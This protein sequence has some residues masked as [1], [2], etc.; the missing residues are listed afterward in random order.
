LKIKRPTY[1]TVEV[2][3]DIRP[4]FYSTLKINEE[5]ITGEPC[6]SKDDAEN[7]AARKAL[8]I[9]EKMYGNKLNFV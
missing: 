2:K 4:T 3:S 6:N 9:L 8:P 1:K 5:G 7:S